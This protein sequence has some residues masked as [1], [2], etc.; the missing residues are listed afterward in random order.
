M[1]YGFAEDDTSEQ[2]EQNRSTRNVSCRHH[3]IVNIA[4]FLAFAVAAAND[5]DR[6]LFS[7][8]SL[9]SPN[10]APSAMSK[11]PSRHRPPTPALTAE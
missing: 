8:S 3:L 7:S 1:G 2:C 4:P 6:P 5:D 10:S 11:P 9:P